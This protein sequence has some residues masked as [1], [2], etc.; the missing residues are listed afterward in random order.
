MKKFL[1]FIFL[2]CSFSALAQVPEPAMLWMKGYGGNGVD[3]VGAAVVKTADSG[4]IIQISS[5]SDSGNGNLDSFC[6]LSGDRSI[7]LKFNAEG[8]DIDWSLCT[9]N[10]NYL[11]PISSGNY[12]LGGLSDASGWAFKVIKL[13]NSGAIL[14]RKTFGNGGNAIL[15]SMIATNDGA[16]LMMGEVNYIDTDI[17]IHYGSW[18]DADLWVLKVDS[19][20]NKIWS[21]VLGGTYNE[22]GVTLVQ[23]PNNG[24]YVVGSTQSNDHD[25]TGYHGGGGDGYLARLDSNGK[26]IWHKD[27]GGS[28]QDGVYGWAISDG[29]G[30]VI[31]TSGSNSADG[32]VHHHVYNGF[33]YWVLDVDSSG[34]ILWENCFGGGGRELPLTICKAT[35]GSTWV[36]G[37]SE[38][39]GGQVDTFYDNLNYDGWLVHADSVGIFLSAKVLGSN[40]LDMCQMLY[41]LKD[42]TVLAGGYFSERNGTFS[43]LTSYGSGDAFLAEFAN[44][45]T[46]VSQVNN[47]NEIQ[48]NPNPASEQVTIESGQ[49]GNYDIL[50]MDAIG[51]CIYS[52]RFTGKIQL[53]VGGWLPGIYYI[54]VVN[55]KGFKNVQKLIVQH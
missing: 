1:G 12:I 50:V 51:S 37:E 53:S 36:G 46:G 24:C 39:Q 28:G 54:Q 52:N 15:R 29:K 11:F 4:F 33:N 6:Y 34:N 55:A 9:A 2:L 17:L 18:M 14:W 47:E 22:T 25:C 10:G 43:S 8:T 35:D 32:D 7:F 48:I 27:L 26:V 40:D 41:P 38:G 5:T 49:H 30:G 13:D 16:F 21:I 45:A 3:Q 20:G 23:A 19:N 44:W 31:I 42:G